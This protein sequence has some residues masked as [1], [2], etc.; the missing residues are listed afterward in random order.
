MTA[1]FHMMALFVGCYDAEER[2]ASRGRA[3]H[4]IVKRHRPGLRPQLYAPRNDRPGLTC[5][6]FDEQSPSTRTDATRMR[7]WL[8]AAGVSAVPGVPPVTDPA[9]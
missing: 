9:S 1:L 8:V 5:Y 6:R 4:D 2:P 3:G 7:G